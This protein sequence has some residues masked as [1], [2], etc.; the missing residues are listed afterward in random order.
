MP[1]NL[2]D[3]ECWLHFLVV[4]QISAL[5]ENHAMTKLQNLVKC[6]R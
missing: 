2:D 1:C 3:E 6:S 4:V 5:I